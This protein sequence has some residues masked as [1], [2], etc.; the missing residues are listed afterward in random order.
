MTYRRDKKAKELCASQYV[1]CWDGVFSKAECPKGLV[2]NAETSQCDFKENSHLTVRDAKMAH[3]QAAARVSSGTV[4]E[5]LSRC[6]GVSMEPTSILNLY[7]FDNSGKVLCPEDGTFGLDCNRTF[8][9]CADGYA[10]K[11]TC[12]QGLAFDMGVSRC[13]YIENVSGCT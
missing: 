1:S 13:A 7:E 8:W 6:R 11:R 3:M 10:V 2:F 4:L 5:D 9:I 12:P